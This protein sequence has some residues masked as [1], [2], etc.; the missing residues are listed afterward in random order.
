MSQSI[1]DLHVNIDAIAEYKVADFPPWSFKAA[2]Y[3]FDLS[4]QKKS[5]TDNNTFQTKYLELKDI[6]SAYQAI[7]TDGSK[8]G[9]NVASAAV[10]G[11]KVKKCRLPDKSSVFSA[12]VKAIDLALSIAVES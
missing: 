5:D 11:H 10:S 1:E 2:N 12:E 6:Y 4:Q 8:D 9:D 7:Y 3:H